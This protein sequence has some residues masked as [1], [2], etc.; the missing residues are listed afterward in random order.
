MARLLVAL[1]IFGSLVSSGIAEAIV[2][3]HTEPCLKGGVE[4]KTGDTLWAI[5]DGPRW[6]E[7][8]QDNPWL[9]AEGRISRK[10]PDLTV[11]RIY[12][13]EFIC[14]ARPEEV[15]ADL[16]VYR[17]DA[18]FRPVVESE[19]KTD[20]AKTEPYYYSPWFWLAAILAIIIAAIALAVYIGRVVGKQLPAAAIDGDPATA[21]PPVIPGGLPRTRQAE[22]SDRLDQVALRRLMEMSPAANISAARPRR[23]SEIREGMLSGTARIHYASGV[24]QTRIFRNEPAYSARFE[25]PDGTQEDMYFLQRCA[26]DAFRV[27]EGQELIFEPRENAAP[28][29]PAPPPQLVPASAVLETGRVQMTVGNIAISVIGGSVSVAPEGVVV[30]GASEVSVRPAPR[31][32]K[33]QPTRRP[34]AAPPAGS[35]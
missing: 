29:A 32:A 27:V 10:S 33:R 19:A 7:L 11:A 16:P 23:V 8:K 26:N 4:V 18:M 34:A 22:I 17:G 20:L 9:E 2:T 25:F 28:V 31:R 6:V 30:R 5:H 14:G 15:R 24:T 13:G 12:Q 3:L 35:R 21:G 1:I